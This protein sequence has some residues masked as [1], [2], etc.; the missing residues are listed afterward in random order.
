MKFLLSIIC[1]LAS[2]LTANAQLINLTMGAD[3]TVLQNGIKLPSGTTI[4]GSA[5]VALA[6]ITSSSANAL[7]TGPN[8]AT[9]PSFNVDASTSS[10]ATGFNVKSA[11][12]A[13]GVALSVISSGT[14]ESVTFDAK[15]AGTVTINGTATGKVILGAE[16]RLKAIATPVAAAGAA[17]GVAGA[18][19]LGVGNYAYV[20]SDGATKGVK[21]LTGA[22]GDWKFVINTSSTALNLFAASG[23]TINGGATNAGCTIAASKGVVAFCS[24]AD[25]W[26]VFDLA[27]H[28]GAAQ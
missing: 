6:T 7:T 10:A 14:D 15:G 9:N 1:A 27:A 17:G 25:T 4:G 24:A 22:L 19:A 2:A 3:G 23:G 5:V 12:A 21:F 8:G 18:A 16:S 13:A 28:A 11:A 20:S 26:I